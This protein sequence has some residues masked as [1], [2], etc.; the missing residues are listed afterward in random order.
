MQSPSTRDDVRLLV[1]LDDGV[2][3]AANDRHQTLTPDWV[4]SHQGDPQRRPVAR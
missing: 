2:P 3:A 1:M 4:G